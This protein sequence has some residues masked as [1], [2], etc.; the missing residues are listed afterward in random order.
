MTS[1][2]P[3]GTGYRVAQLSH[4]PFFAETQHLPV[5]HLLSHVGQAVGQPGQVGQSGHQGQ[6][7]HVTP[8]RSAMNSGIE[9][10]LT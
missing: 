3:T 6:M 1:K 8:R 7:G 5:S 2:C 4:P 9:R 10:R